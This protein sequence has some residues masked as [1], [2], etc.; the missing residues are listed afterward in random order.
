MN[1]TETILNNEPYRNETP[2]SY[3]RRIA[4][5]TGSTTNAI[6]VKYQKLHKRGLV[7]YIGE[8]KVKN[9][10]EISG[11][12]L[13]SDRKL[14]FEKDILPALINTGNRAQEKLNVKKTQYI[15]I[16]RLPFMIVPLSDIHGGAKCDYEAIV[17]DLKLIRDTQ[18][19]YAIVAGDV[20]DNFIIGK[21]TAIQ[22][23]QPTTLD[24]EI[25]F[26][27]WFCKMIAEKILVWVSGNHDNWTYKVSGIDP[28]KYYL[29]NSSCL[30]DRN[31]VVFDLCHDDMSEKWVIRHKWRGNSIFNPTHGME[32]SWE[33]NGDDFDVAIGGHTHIATLHRP[34][35]KHDK[36][37]HAVLIGTYKLLDEYGKELG[38]ANTHS[39]SRGS[40][41]FVYDKN[42]KK[43]WFDSVEEGVDYL[44]YLK[45][46]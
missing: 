26:A 11:S 3:Y 1:L 19:C 23:H 24:E 22:K 44:N 17:K 46:K 33:R 39:D 28:Y 32:V 30:Y 38:F 40:G 34:F 8:K 41:A 6:R 10:V 16:N 9:N 27:E 13:N 4:E 5:L 2:F 42:F 21:L 15:R 29:K 20:T 43:K 25:L 12:T 37:R 36:K 18:D 7:Q 31:E 14:N 45:T 35:I